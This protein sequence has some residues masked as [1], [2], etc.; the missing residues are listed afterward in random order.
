MSL[1]YLFQMRNFS[2]SRILRRPT[3]SADYKSQKLWEERFNCRLLSDEAIIKRI[4]NKIISEDDLNTLELDIFINIA[5]P[6]REETVQLK[7]SARLIKKFR[8]SVAAHTLLPSTHHALCRLFLTSS[9]LT[10]LITLLDKRVDYG[11]FPDFFATNLLLDEAL[12]KKEYALAA[13]LASLVMLQEEFSINPITDNMSLYSIAKYI[14]SKT[15]FED[16]P[17]CDVTQDPILGEP[18]DESDVNSTVNENEAEV[19]NK[20]ENNEE[21]EEEEEED[22]E[23][24]R[25]PFL[26]NPYF[27][28]HFDL[29][30]PRLICGKSMSMLASTFSNKDDVTVQQTKLISNILLGH[31]TSAITSLDSCRNLNYLSMPLQ[32]VALFYLDNL[33]SVEAPKDEESAALR[34]GLT[35]ATKSEK[36]L[37]EL[38]ESIYKTPHENEKKD[39]GDLRTSFT[40]CSSMRENILKKLDDFKAREELIAEIK[41]KKEELKLQEQYLYFYENLKKKRVTRI[42]YK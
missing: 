9:S 39:I 1:R 33:H 31:W 29:T 23:Y 7:E 2:T 14:E 20:E 22:A 41:A 28:N 8:R 27:D 12:D 4:N 17:K 11:I 21:G 32:E 37:S 34:S 42:D 3:L 26:R 30:N 35:S 40:E 15:N 24:I 5:S 6:S 25:V 19:E 18:K 36:P 38:V 13:K 16:W 10:S